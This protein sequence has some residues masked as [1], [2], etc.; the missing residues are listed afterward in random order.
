MQKG[1]REGE[2]CICREQHYLHD[3][4]SSRANQDGE[5]QC[6]FGQFIIY[7]KIEVCQIEGTAGEGYHQHSLIGPFSACKGLPGEDNT[8]DGA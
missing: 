4:I 3:D 2:T 8:D 6:L 5:L 1:V 7:A